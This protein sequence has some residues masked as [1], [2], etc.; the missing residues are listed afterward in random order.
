MAFFANT[1]FNLALIIIYHL[2]S[3][4][5]GTLG[6]SSETIVAKYGDYVTLNCT[7]PNDVEK[8]WLFAEYV[9][10]NNKAHVYMNISVKL[11]DDYSLEIS[12]VTLEHEG[13]YKCINESLV[14]DI[15]VLTILGMYQFP[16]LL[17]NF[18][19]FDRF[20]TSSDFK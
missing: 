5:Y 9:L 1:V 13:T 3:G 16:S 20:Y 6:T 7:V 18:I 11:G 19:A 10:F 17:Y 15:Y 2:P 4:S 14:S 8:I 12:N